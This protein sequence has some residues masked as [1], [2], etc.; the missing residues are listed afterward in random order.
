MK[1]FLALAI[2]FSA[3]AFALSPVQPAYKSTE[4]FRCAQG[5]ETLSIQ[6]L[7]IYGGNDS[8]AVG[9]FFDYQRNGVSVY[10]STGYLAPRFVAAGGGYYEM[11]GVGEESGNT[12]RMGYSSEVLAGA[13]EGRR[14]S[15]SLVNCNFQHA[16]YKYSNLG[17]PI[18]QP[19]RQ[20][21]A[22]RKVYKPTPYK[23]I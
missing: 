12:L 18:P 20:P 19:A 8:Y 6:V 9:T 13:L 3:G 10:S 5:N 21:E 15:F 7:S 14:V 11:V 23:K 17:T 2:L 4:V 16:M 1:S 22:P